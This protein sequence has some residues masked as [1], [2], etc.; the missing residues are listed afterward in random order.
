MGFGHVS[1]G[2]Q[3]MLHIGAGSQK[4]GRTG[5]YHLMHMSMKKQSCSHPY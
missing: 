3:D 1:A 2:Q 4:R 5:K